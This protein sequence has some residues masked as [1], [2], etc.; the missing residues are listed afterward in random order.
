MANFVAP[1]MA[2]RSIHIIALLLV[3]C[4]HAHPQKRVQIR[5]AVCDSTT[6]KP[7]SFSTITL[8]SEAGQLFGTSADEAGEFALAL[9]HEGTYTVGISYV[10][11]RPQSYTLM[12]CHGQQLRF[13][14]APTAHDIESVVVTATTTKEQLT[15]ASRIDRTAMEHLQPTSFSDL[16]ALL[17]GGQTS[18]P[19]MSAANTIALRQVPIASGQYATGALGTQFVIDGH[20]VS[21]D[22]NLQRVSDDIST[23]FDSRSSVG[24]G[25]DMR[26]ISTDNIESVEVVRGIPSV[27]YGDLTDGV[28]IIERKHRATP[29]EARF[30][31]DEYGKLVHVGKGVEWEH[32]QLVL[33]ADAGFLDSHHDP[34]DRLNSYR[35]LNGSMR[36]VKR[37][38]LPNSLTLS[39]NASADYAGNLDTQKRDPDILS[40][41][42][43]NF[44]AS[45]HSTGLNATMRL[46]GGSDRAF[47]SLSLT[48]HA[49]ASF[50]R[51]E[52]TKFVQLDRDR[53]MPTNT[54]EGVHDAAILPYKYYSHL[55]VD[56]KPVNLFAN[57]K[58]VFNLRTGAATHR[59]SGGI[60]LKYDKNLGDGQVY[61]PA[62]PINIYLATRPR[63]YR[64]IP[65]MSQLS[66]FVEDKVLLP[67]GS[68]ELQV[69]MGLRA[70]TLLNLS[71]HAM[72]GRVYLDPRVNIRYLLP[73]IAMGDKHLVF[74]L[75]GG[76]G[77]LT[78]MPTL[79][80]LHPE[81]L[82]IDLVQ[83]NYWHKNADYKRIN[84]R[85]YIVDCTNPQLGPASNFK[86]EVSAGAEYGHNTLVIT[87]FRERMSSGFRSTAQYTPYTYNAYDATGI[88]HAALTAPPDIASLPYTTDTVLRG[89]SRITNGS[90]T[91]KE[92]IE[93]VLSTERFKGINTRFTLN[94]AW[95]RTT[96]RNSQPVWRTVSQVVAGVSMSDLYAARYVDDDIYIREQLNSNLTAD[97]YLPTLGTKL[98][99]TLECSWFYAHQSGRKNGLP[100]AYMGIDGIEH[101]YTEADAAD[102]YRRL[103]I[104]HYAD[105]LFNR[106]VEPFYCYL[107]FKATKDFE[108]VQ[109]S[110]FADRIL[111]YMPDYRSNG[112]LVRRTAASPYFG[113][114]INLK[115]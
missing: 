68:T 78:K 70:N 56:G 106:Y 71:S 57:L 43:D 58:S 97:V 53:A 74:S 31:S 17:P 11:Y 92:G 44:A 14:L 20:P 48:V 47:R 81:L 27:E 32:R 12:L 2:Y 55:T 95:F 23:S 108:H 49:N 107:N 45:Y 28:V 82:Y 93:F 51:I 89:S 64:D 98:S 35:R 7:L 99:T 65:A 79:A 30:K 60:T 1:I 110:L 36:G 24:A 115:I 101:P 13:A 8:R 85:T 16:L 9:P 73:R 62:R 75:Q 34:R 37:W 83:L 6:S 19:N 4:T 5:G 15:S 21:T 88:D 61:D 22:A 72:R 50:D 52:R 105:G 33:S 109:V 102:P 69:Q 87:Y 59:L 29:L 54:A 66:A 25:V 38:A 76:T 114:E 113:M 18:T 112:L 42:E 40:Q 80:H 84:L 91:L 39:L 63:R 10:G 67:L 94:G 96:Y 90:Q 41:P 46:F 104:Q 3:L 111:D 86:W 26:T 100:M 103:L 77:W